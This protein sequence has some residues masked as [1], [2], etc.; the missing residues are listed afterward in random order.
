MSNVPERL[1]FKTIP[2]DDTDTRYMVYE[3]PALADDCKGD[4][5]ADTFTLAHAEEIAAAP[6]LLA[7]AKLALRIAEN[8][9]TDEFTGTGEV[10]ERL[11]GLDPVR[12]AIKKA[13]A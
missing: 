7:A 10:Q 5:V 2:W 8:V 9:I 13:G 4:R 3:N 1:I 6:D 11:A 12:A